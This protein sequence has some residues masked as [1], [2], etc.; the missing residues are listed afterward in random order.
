VSPNHRIEPTR[1][2]GLP[3]RLSTPLSTTHSKHFVF[4][5]VRRLSSVHSCCSDVRFE[6]FSPR[7]WVKN[8][9]ESKKES[10]TRIAAASHVKCDVLER[11]P[12]WGDTIHKREREREREIERTQEQTRQRDRERRRRGGGRRREIGRGMEREMRRRGERE[13]E[14]RDKSDSPELPLYLTL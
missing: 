2:R 10:T 7:F 4:P 1:H 13:Q 8:Y 12:A 6:P 9:P 14:K 5:S 3:D 11:N